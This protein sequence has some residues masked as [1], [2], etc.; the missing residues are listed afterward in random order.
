MIQETIKIHD[1]FQFEI[2]VGYKLAKNESK[3]TFEIDSYFFSPSSL[4]VNKDTYSRDSFFS[5]MQVY[6]RFKTPSKILEELATPENEL[7]ASLKTTMQKLAS[8]REVS[9]FPEYENKLKL[10]SCVVKAALRDHID[11]LFAKTNHLVVDILL[12]KFLSCVTQISSSFRKLREIISVPGFPEKRFQHFRF[13]DEYLSLLI[14]QYAFKAIH[15]VSKRNSS[16]L[17]KVDEIKDLIRSETKYREENE[18]PSI[19]KKKDKNESFLYRFSVLKKFMGSILF[20]NVQRQSEIKIAEHIFYALAAGISMVVATGAAFYAQMRLGNLSF[21]FFV[22]LVISYMFK[23]R[24]KAIFQQFFSSQIRRFFFDQKERIFYNPAETIGICQES[25]DF[26]DDKQVPPEIRKIRNCDHLT[27]I[28]NGWVGQS[29]F[30]YSRRIELFSSVIRKTFQEIPIVT[31]NDIIRFNISRFLE[32]MDDPKRNLYFLE[33][34]NVETI[35]AERAY[36]LNL[37]IKFSVKKERVFYKRF[38][39]ILN[40]DGINRLEEVPVDF[41]I[42]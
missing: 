21:P 22:A 36:H 29:V 28:E 25:F 17:A 33:G 41:L 15:L 4:G 27:E 14:E 31:V 9:E 2:K 13:C 18:F 35:T 7:L 39:I 37:I 26:L 38:R 10:Y 5:D 11:C 24:I 6:I 16:N 23:D 8:S 40:R 34:E 19:V 42:D 3:T 20:L 12:K 32:K 1:K 30:Q